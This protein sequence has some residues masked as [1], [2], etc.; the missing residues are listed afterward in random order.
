[1]GAIRFYQVLLSPL[2][3]ILFGT[4]GSCRYSPTCSEYA[5]EAISRHGCI[6]G[7]WLAVKRI[8][9]CHPLGGVGYDPVPDRC[10]CPH[11]HPHSP[12]PD[13]SRH[14]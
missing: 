7:T 11:A 12:T 8:S 9:R 10:A 4:T 3:F 1:M 14:G 13:D 6:T 2:K 5:R